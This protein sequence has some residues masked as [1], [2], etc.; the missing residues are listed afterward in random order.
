[1]TTLI[2]RGPR[3][4][5]VVTEFLNS[6]PELFVGQWRND[7]DLAT[8]RSVTAA[9]YKDERITWRPASRAEVERATNR[10]PGA[11]ASYCENDTCI[12]DTWHT[13]EQAARD[14]ADIDHGG[15]LS[16]WQQVKTDSLA[17]AR[18]EAR[19]ISNGG[20]FDSGY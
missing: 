7:I 18:A 19:R 9:S 2:A 3:G 11:A 13:D 10:R 4:C 20:S 8:P 1:M 17:H 16:C 15:S 14:H 6:M 12:S 5:R